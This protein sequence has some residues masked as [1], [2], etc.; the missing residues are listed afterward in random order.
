MG[1]RIIPR[2]TDRE[3]QAQHMADSAHLRIDHR[4][5]QPAR[6]QPMNDFNQRQDQSEDE[7][8]NASVAASTQDSANELIHVG[9]N[10]RIS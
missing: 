3:N 5:D 9:A 7:R 6:G 10:R 8:R 4:T 1:P 2:I